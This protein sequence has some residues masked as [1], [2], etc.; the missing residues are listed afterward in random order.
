[1]KLG[2]FTKTFTAPTLD[3]KLAAVR[4]HGMADVQF[5]LS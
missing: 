4:A 2:I 3:A 5:N 1:M